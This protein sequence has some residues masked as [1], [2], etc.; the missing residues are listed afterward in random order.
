[1]DLITDK[2]QPT[3]E[4]TEDDALEAKEIEVAGIIRDE[5]GNEWAIPADNVDD[6]GDIASNPFSVMK[7]DER[8]HY[9]IEPLGKVEQK[10]LEGFVPVLR[11]E[12]GIS[13][14]LDIEYG[15]PT[16][17]YVQ[18]A[19][20]VLMKIP[21][22]L[23]DRRYARKARIAKEVVEQTEPTAEMLSRK[24]RTNQAQL[25]SIN[26]TFDKIKNEAEFKLERKTEIGD[27]P[28]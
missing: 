15:K 16:S 25:R 9:Q 28:R 20:S 10:R 26:D 12:V 22:V 23:A 5:Y 24:P 11:E 2:P 18:Y 17:N 21:K 3:T 8:F 4:P 1:M 14:T 13:K 7:F 27:E 19:D 6:I